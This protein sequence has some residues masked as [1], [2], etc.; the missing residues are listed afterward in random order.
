MR[1]DAEGDWEVK[2][3]KTQE[4]RHKSKERIANFQEP[5]PL[6]E[7]IRGEA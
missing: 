1:G 5:I 2:G 4:V 3:N 6:L 7:V